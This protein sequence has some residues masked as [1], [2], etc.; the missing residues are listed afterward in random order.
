[1][2]H[3]NRAV[4][5]CEPKLFARFSGSNQGFTPLYQYARKLPNACKWLMGLKT[6]CNFPNYL[7]DKNVSPASKLLRFAKSVNHSPG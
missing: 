4:G 6:V 2:A 5:N 3:E 7:Y 1:M